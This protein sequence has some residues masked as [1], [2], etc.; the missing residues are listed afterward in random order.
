M[1]TCWIDDSAD[2]D[3]RVLTRILD[4]DASLPD[5]DYS[6]RP[7][8]LTC[9]A[10]W[11]I[12][13]GQMVYVRV[14]FARR[15]R[16]MAHANRRNPEMLLDLVKAN[17]MLRFMQRER[18]QAGTIPCVGATREDFHDAAR[19]YGQLNG[20]S[21]G[22][23]TKL[24]RKES[25]LLHTISQDTWT[26]FTIPQLQKKTGWSNG[27]LH[28]I[29]HG[30]DSRGC[31][32]SGLLEKCPAISFCDRTLVSADEPGVFSVRRRTNAYSFD[33]ALFQSWSQG[34]MV[35]LDDHDDQDRPSALQQPFSNPP[36]G[37]EGFENNPEGSDSPNTRY[38]KNILLC[39]GISSSKCRDAQHPESS[40]VSV[41]PCVC[42]PEIAEV[43]KDTIEKSS[44]GSPI[45]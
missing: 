15:I 27:T 11:E 9:R 29:I 5:G 44:Q 4:R 12:V 43:L 30:Y 41:P 8:V 35:W 18:F 33:H 7:D 42:D 10:I 31:T 26:E 17:A 22:Q 24:T 20:T 23:E 21:G 19:L 28:R 40:Q 25:D 45:P 39:T 32:Y 6:E 36:A 14:P 37:A 2:Q 3:D 1:L 16:F 13:A 34:G 38:N